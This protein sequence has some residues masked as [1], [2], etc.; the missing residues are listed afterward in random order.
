MD[1]LMNH[2]LADVG[3]TAHT[4]SGINGESGLILSFS[5]RKTIVKMRM[6]QSYLEGICQWN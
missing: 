6:N 4:L 3:E 2:S 1:G 5:G